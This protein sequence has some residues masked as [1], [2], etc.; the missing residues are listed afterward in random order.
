[1]LDSLPLLKKINFPA[2]N[3]KKIEIL[4]INLGYRCNQQCQHCHVN[5]GPNRKET[6]SSET[7]LQ[8]IAFIKNN[9]IEC[10]DLTGGAPEMH[11]DFVFL[12]KTLHDMNVEVIDRCNLTILNEA[13][14]LN[15]D[16]QLAE[17]QVKI[18][19][20]MPCY[21]EENVNKQRGS[22]VFKSSIEALKSLNDL[23]YGQQNSSLILNL[24]YNPQGASLAPEQGQLETDYKNFLFDQYGIVFNQLYTI[25]NVPVKRFGSMLMSTNEFEPYMSLLQDNYQ[26]D[27]LNSVM[28]RNLLSI[29]WQG[30]LYDC[31][32]NQ[33]LNL[34]MSSEKNEKLH[35]SQV[36][37][38]D[39]KS[40]EI[41]VAGHCYACTAGQGS[42]CGGALS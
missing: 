13:A 19:A 11:P 6:M 30:Y 28:C 18:V 4:Q 39:L 38:A 26:T 12:I 31:D 7:V 36:T 2:I 41:I 40:K 8:I 5:A 33:M 3:R 37:A 27:N 20:S 42:S 1:M 23:G 32:F 10:V 34:P 14:Y 17:N 24:V 25:T 22:G 9:Q 35:I 16:K 15:I 21:L 29:D